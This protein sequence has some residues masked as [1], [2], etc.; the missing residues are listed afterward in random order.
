MRRTACFSSSRR[1]SSMM[2]STS[3]ASPFST[4]SGSAEIRCGID[5][6]ANVSDCRSRSSSFVIIGKD[7]QRPRAGKKKWNGGEFLS[8]LL[9]GNVDFSQIAPSH[10]H[11]ELH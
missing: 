3:F 10:E 11:R 6:S 2:D 7:L 1:T 5:G 8:K 9:A 4:T